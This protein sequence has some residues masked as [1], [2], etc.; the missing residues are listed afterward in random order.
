[1]TLYLTSCVGMIIPPVPSSLELEDLTISSSYLILWIL[2]RQFRLEI[3][4]L[5]TLDTFALQL[6]SK[7]QKYLHQ[8]Y[9]SSTSEFQGLMEIGHCPALTSLSLDSCKVHSE[10]LI[11]F[12]RVNPQLKNLSVQ[13]TTF[14]ISHPLT[15][16]LL[17]THCP[18]LVHF[19][20]SGNTSFDN[21]SVSQLIECH[22]KSLRSLVLDETSVKGSQPF[23]ELHIAHPLLQSISVRYLDLPLETHLFLFRKIVLRSLLSD[24]PTTQLLAVNDL[25]VFFSLGNVSSSLSPLNE[26]YSPADHHVEIEREFM[27][28][29]GLSRI[30]EFLTSDSLVCHSLSPFLSHLLSLHLLDH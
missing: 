19:N 25:F 23:L 22:C 29:F 5:E 12:L 1:V 3:I 24:H 4:T 14:P 28:S 20:V 16:A 13:R 30:I 10:H 21:N 26:I 7:S 8:L 9:L 6:I 27:K 18:Q 15:L 2:D 17:P 11:K